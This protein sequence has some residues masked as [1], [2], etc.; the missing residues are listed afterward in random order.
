MVSEESKARAAAALAAGYELACGKRLPVA[1]YGTWAMPE[2]EE[3]ALAVCNAILAGYRLID[4]A[5][6][7]KN[8]RSVGKGIKAAIAA[9]VPREELTITSKVWV[10]NL[11]YESTKASCKQTLQDL[12]LEYLD[13][14]LI[15]WPASPN[16]HDNWQ[17]LNLA[18]WQAMM[19]LYEDG[20]VRA[21]GVSNFWPH[22]LEN[23]LSTRIRPMVN[24]IE[25]HPGYSHRDLVDFCHEH[26][27]VVEGWAPFGRGA[28]LGHDTI[29]AIA[30]THG[31][32]AAQ[33]CLAFARQLKVIPLPKSANAQ[34]LVSNL[35]FLDITLSEAEMAQLLALDSQELG[36][37]HE[38]PDY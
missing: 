23:L 30:A 38:H 11:G 22:H 15:H 4:G 8:E 28:V 17:E 5:A 33:V 16:K 31:C 24:Q 1:G 36:Y 34:R 2:G 6:F 29:N 9:G 14:L 20:L 19:E 10:D 7:Y 25:V 12:G 26:G 21:I 32:T 37:S 18:T 13:L 27:M 35:E 3:C